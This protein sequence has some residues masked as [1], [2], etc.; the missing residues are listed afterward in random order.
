M[1]LKNKVVAITGAGGVICSAFAKAL[2]EEGAKV[3]LLDI[4]YEAAKAYAEYVFAQYEVPKLIATIKEDNI[5]SWKV[6]QK[7]GFELETSKRYQDI[8]DEKEELYRFYVLKGTAED[9]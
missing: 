8:N 9:E 3:A 7:V 2:A 1:K 5:S 6:A 4:N